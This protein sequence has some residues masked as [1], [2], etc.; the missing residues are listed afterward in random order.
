MNTHMNTH[1]TA[2]ASF[3]AIALMAALASSAQADLITN[4]GF[5]SWAYPGNSALLNNSD[6][7]A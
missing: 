4:G 7:T 2:M 1:K 3:S 6:M 5:E